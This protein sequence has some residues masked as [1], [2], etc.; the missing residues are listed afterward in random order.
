MGQNGA[1]M[2]HFH[3]PPPRQGIIGVGV[4][5]GGVVSWQHWSHCRSRWRLPLGVAR[6]MVVF[7]AARK[8][9]VELMLSERH[10]R[11]EFESNLSVFRG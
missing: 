3:P 1:K 9:K 7:L 8:R 6:A 11:A 4:G 5:V 2:R 10:Q